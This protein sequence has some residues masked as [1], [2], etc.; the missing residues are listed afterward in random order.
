M[1]DNNP[2]QKALGGLLGGILVVILIGIPLVALLSMMEAEDWALL[3][4]AA[5][6]LIVSYL[7]KK[8]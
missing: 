1:N 8:R 7:V 4:C 3:I 5:A 2:I 6:F